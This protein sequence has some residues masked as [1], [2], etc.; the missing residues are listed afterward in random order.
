MQKNKLE[1]VLVWVDLRSGEQGKHLIMI[2][3]MIEERKKR[4]FR[5]NRVT[6]FF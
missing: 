1:I 3:T 6:T 4:I 5:G 2:S